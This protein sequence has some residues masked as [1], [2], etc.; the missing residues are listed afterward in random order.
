MSTYLS[1][2]IQKLAS[3]FQY[4][5]F[6]LLLAAIVGGSVVTWMRILGT[7]QWI[8][9]E[10]GSAFL[11]AL[12]GVIQL[13]VQIPI[14]LWAGTLAD[15]LDRKRLMTVS[16]GITALTLLALGLLNA[17]GLLS[18]FF[19]YIG[20]AITAATHMMASPAASAM[21]PV[22]I[23]E[24][25][26]IPA[27]STDTAFRNMAAILG[28]LLFAVIATT[29]DITT[30]F[31][32][33]SVIALISSLLPFLVKAE[34]KA[35]KPEDHAQ[36]SQLELTLEGLRYTAKHPILPGLFLLDAGITTASFYREILPVLA[37]GL[38]A[39]GAS[40]TGML[41]AANSTGAILGS[42]TAVLLV[43]FKAKG[44]MVLY[45]SFAYGFFL[46]GFGL[47]NSLLIGILMIALLGA[48][49]AVTVTVRQ[50]TV[51][52]TTPDHMR[53]RAFALL[54]LAA[55]TANNVGTI[56]VGTWAGL[57]GASN[58]MVMGGVISI[59]MTALIWW[60]WKPI[61]EYRSDR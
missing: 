19:V 15:H 43:G 28:P 3:A 39:G 13:V 44:M 12:I 7:S 21:I 38:F 11:V 16:H 5:D 35:E 58:T 9:D 41:G 55:Q 27:N 6:R 57:I 18:P 37:L 32:T 8:L 33:G 50:T 46:F 22:I 17:A 25:D 52:L 45:A 49:D 51:M 36:K 47:A 10:T 40:A 14:T 20:I 53:G 23:P 54:V 56:W 24:E 4:S 60:L 34:G 61:R 59:V 31:L 48:A 26:L 30:V 29:L 2:F 1:T 42:L